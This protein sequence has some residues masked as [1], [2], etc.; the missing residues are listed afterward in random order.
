MSIAV[1]I[2]WRPA[3]SPMRVRW[4]S[5]AESTSPQRT[6]PLLP[7]E[8]PILE[9]TGQTTN[10]YELMGSM[11]ARLC[12]RVNMQEMRGAVG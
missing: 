3:R 7:V 2:A 1:L 4:L 12:P 6:H 11:A 5:A 8:Y 10:E 9:A